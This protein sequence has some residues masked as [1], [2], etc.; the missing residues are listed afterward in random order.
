[1]A[2]VIIGFPESG[3]GGY[4]RGAFQ[5]AAVFRINR[6]ILFVSNLVG[7]RDFRYAVLY[8]R[9]LQ[10]MADLLGVVLQLIHHALN[11]IMLHKLGSLLLVSLIPLHEAELLVLVGNRFARLTGATLTKIHF[12]WS[13]S[14]EVVVAGI[15]GGSPSALLC[16]YYL[17]CK[18]DERLIVAK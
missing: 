18:I 9:Q 13:C 16:T 15:S 5:F 10:S 2:G 4:G 12:V 17:S 6:G 3:F 8:R 11:I 1:M 14:I 7:E